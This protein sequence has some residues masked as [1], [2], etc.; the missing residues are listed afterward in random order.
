MVSCSLECLNYVV[1]NCVVF[2]LLGP[3]LFIETVAWGFSS[4]LLNFSACARAENAPS[5]SN[6]PRFTEGEDAKLVDLK[7]RRGW[8]WEDFQRSFLGRSTGSLQMRY[9]TKLKERNTAL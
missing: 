9:S 2:C 6:R 5:R 1:T 8:S 7:E 3:G 4:Q